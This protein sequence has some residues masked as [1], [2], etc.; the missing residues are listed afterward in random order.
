MYI[1]P[2]TGSKYGKYFEEFS[3]WGM[4]IV[5]HTGACTS[6]NPLS[7]TCLLWHVHSIY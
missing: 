4:Y 7:W 5:P 1:A 6:F 3:L 2:H